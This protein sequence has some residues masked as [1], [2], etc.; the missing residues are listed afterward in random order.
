M[1]KFLSQMVVMNLL[2][3]CISL[4]VVASVKPPQKVIRHSGIYRTSTGSVFNRVWHAKLGWGWKT[5]DGKL[6]SSSQG[7]LHNLGTPNDHGVVIGSEAA[8]ACD[9]IDGR[10]P[11]L[12]DYE[13]LFSHFEHTLEANLLTLTQRGFRELLVLFPEVRQAGLWTATAVSYHSTWEPTWYDSRYSFCVSKE[14]RFCFAH[15][16]LDERASVRCIAD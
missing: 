12:E 2:M 6:W 3:A 1:S 8:D 7:R 9:R 16:G 14:G 15:G 5:P 11:T 10:L 13:K 4:P